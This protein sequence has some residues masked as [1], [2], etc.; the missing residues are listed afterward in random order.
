MP[1]A[2]QRGSI[3]SVMQNGVFLLPEREE[4]H[5]AAFACESSLGFDVVL[6]RSQRFHAAQ[7]DQP[8]NLLAL[9]AVLEDLSHVLVKAHSGEEALKCLLRDDFA[10]ILM[11]VFMPGID[12][13]E[14]AELIRQRERWRF[15]PQAAR[16]VARKASGIRSG[17]AFRIQGF[18]ISGSTSLV[19]NSPRVS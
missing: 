14:T 16:L 9:E 7:D 8:S 19:I 15:G 10:V 6:S 5:V 3:A 1:V 13:F 2:I 18:K 17:R 11:D 12:G 4:E